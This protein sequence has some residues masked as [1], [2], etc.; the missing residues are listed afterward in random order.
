MNQSDRLLSRRQLQ[1]LLGVS[2]T[3]L[4]RML[5]DGSLPEPVRLGRLLKW[6]SRDVERY[7]DTLTSGN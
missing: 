3:T 7:L 4:Y 5:A 6:R 1:D 2:R